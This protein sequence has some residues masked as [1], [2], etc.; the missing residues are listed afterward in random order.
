M[1]T[2]GVDLPRFQV[3]HPP[4]LDLAIVRSGNDER[5]SWVEDSIVDTTVMT[6]QDILDR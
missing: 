3:T 2:T 4:Q 6:F 1:S 5:K